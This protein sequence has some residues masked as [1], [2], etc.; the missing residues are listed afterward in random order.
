MN[1]ITER[2]GG[3]E[4]LRRAT[5]DPKLKLYNFINYLL[6]F[7]FTVIGLPLAVAW[8]L[9]LGFYWTNRQ[10]KALHCEL[11]SRK[12]SVKRGVLFRVEKT[13]PLEQIQDLTVK[14]GPLLKAFGLCALKIETAGQ[15]ST[16]ASEADL[17]GIVDPRAFRDE[18]LAQ[19]DVLR[20]EKTTATAP[21]SESETL[22]EIRDLLRDIRDQ[23]GA[24]LDDRTS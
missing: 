22:G 4:V 20:A 9:G 6:I 12:L 18:V 14:E 10:F 21:A 13:I 24:A 1:E 19:R 23:I 7:V 8:V 3:E 17:I 11:S 16:G 2:P 5:F 15:S